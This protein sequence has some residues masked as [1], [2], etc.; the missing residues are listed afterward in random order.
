M[1]EYPLWLQEHYEQMGYLPAAALPS[2][3]TFEQELART[4]EDARYALRFRYDAKNRC[5]VATCPQYPR[6]SV[7]GD[8]ETEAEHRY[9]EALRQTLT[10]EHTGNTPAPRKKGRPPKTYVHV[11]LNLPVDIAF[12]FR[13]E[14]E[15]LCLSQNELFKSMLETHLKRVQEKEAKRLKALDSEIENAIAL[16]KKMDA[17]KK[18][19]AKLHSTKNGF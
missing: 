16:E 18:K 5:V 11:H 3:P 9:L 19:Q 14:A 10:D 17:Y 4:V 6:F 15:T 12:S 2:R 13:K 8:S 1:A 7:R